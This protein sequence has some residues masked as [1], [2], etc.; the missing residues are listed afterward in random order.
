MIIPFMIFNQ[1]NRMVVLRCWFEVT[2]DFNTEN[3]SCAN[4]F[5]LDIPKIELVQK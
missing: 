2:V 3:Y 4:Y 5:S 1:N